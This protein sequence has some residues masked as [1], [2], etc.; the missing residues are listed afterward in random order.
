[1]RLASRIV[2]LL[3]SGAVLSGCPAR[4]E[5]F[6]RGNA[7]WLDVEGG[8]T[9]GIG[10]NYQ[11]GFGGSLEAGYGFS[12][13]FALGVE[14]GPA[15]NQPPR[16][17]AS[18]KDLDG[19]KYS[20]AT[21]NLFIRMESIDPITPYFMIGGGQSQF[22]FDYADTGKVII[23]GGRTRK[24]ADDRLKAWCA[25]FGF[26]FDTPLSGHLDG[27]FRGRYIY[28]RWQSR[29][30]QNILFSYPKGDAYSIEANLKFHF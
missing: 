17:T 4:A 9:S 8:R 1:M 16:F 13:R 28:N 23:S 18:T 19:G 29:S 26:G 7:G 30:V 14:Y 11:G 2:L 22:T 24:I 6:L 15:Y 5:F 12:N 25:I 3:T 21:G 20:T 27:G 10:D